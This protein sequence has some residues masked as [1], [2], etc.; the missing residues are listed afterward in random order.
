MWNSPDDINNA[1]LRMTINGTQ[2]YSDTFTISTRT[3]TGIGFNC[4]DSFYFYWNKIPGIN[5]Y[6]IY[7]LG[8]KYL[9]PIVSTTDSFIVMEK[10]IN[11]SLYYSVAPLIGNNEGMKSYTLN[12][13]T[14]GVECYIR[15]FLSI[16]RNDS[17]SLD[18]LLGTLYDINKIVLEKFDRTNYVSLQQ[19]TTFTGLQIN[20]IDPQLKN[21]LNIYRIKLELANGRIIYSQ[22]E[23]VYYLSGYKFIIYPNPIQHNQPIKILANYVF[24]PVTLEVINVYGQKIYELIIDETNTLLPSGTLSIGIYFFRFVKNGKEDV[25][26]KVL[27]Q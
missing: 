17:V 14:Q 4:P 24:E 6:T 27:V 10:N 21:G 15:S 13:T 2:Y 25:L 16:L 1:L 7:K 9:Q 23:I 20:L 26:M 11:P 5:N 8:N 3:E 12:Y 18:L 19:L 22:A